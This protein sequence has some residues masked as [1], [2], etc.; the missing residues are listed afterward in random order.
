MIC[1]DCKGA[2][3]LNA[4]VDGVH[5]GGVVQIKCSRC[6]ATGETNPI[7]EQWLRVGGTHRTWRIAQHES[8]RDCSARLNVSITELCDMENGRAE[9][10]RL[11]PDTPKELR[12]RA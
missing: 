4:I 1:P 6:D 5:G 7:R 11:I 10:G 2:K 12:A 9:P 8:I 3:V